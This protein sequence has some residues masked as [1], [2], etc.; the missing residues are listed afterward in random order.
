[1]WTL[2]NCLITPH[3]ANTPEMGLKLLA[4]RVTENLRRY[5]AGED[6][7]GPVDVELGY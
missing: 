2:D 6:L 4:R 1:M 5:I 7:L 3:V